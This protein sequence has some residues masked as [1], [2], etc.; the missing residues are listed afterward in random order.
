M[1]KVLEFGLFT[2]ITAASATGAALSEAMQ[3]YPSIYWRLL[4]YVGA[5]LDRVILGQFGDLLLPV[6]AVGLVGMVMSGA[7]A[8]DSNFTDN[9][10]YRAVNT[11]ATGIGVGLS[12]LAGVVGL[13]SEFADM[14]KS[15]NAECAANLSTCKGDWHDI[16]AFSVPLVAIGISAAFNFALR[17]PDPNHNPAMTLAPRP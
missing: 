6:F 3:S 7:R 10:N 1:N 5:D 13:A 9:P 14:A 16:I 4:P 17:S 15:S 11:L 8:L 2:T 12:G